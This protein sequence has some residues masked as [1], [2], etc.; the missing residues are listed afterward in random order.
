MLYANYV[1]RYKKSMILI[2]NYGYDNSFI[3]MSLLF[4][5]FLSKIFHMLCT[6]LW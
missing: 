2:N 4:I 5:H 6:M 3:H 1:L